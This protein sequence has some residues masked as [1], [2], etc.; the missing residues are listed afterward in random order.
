MSGPHQGAARRGLGLQVQ[1][2]PLEPEE[3]VLIEELLPSPERD[4]HA[5]RLSTQQSGSATYYV[6]WLGARP[7]GHA[8]VRWGGS[9]NP[10]LNS[11]QAGPI[12]HPYIE[13][14]AVHPA[15]QSRGIGTKIIS[16][17]EH[18]SIRR[19]HSEIGLA[20]SV[21]NVRARELYSRLGFQDLGLGEF[22][23]IWSY[24]DDT[25][26]RHVE[27]ETCVYLMKSLATP[28]DGAPDSPDL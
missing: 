28:S 17:V 4:I 24:R 27:I 5:R 23:N 20:V 19:G 21:E 22:P 13:G 8:L 14:L 18:E 1:V 11:T 12:V 16:A 3:L 6:A 2:L 26:Q 10:L 7:V 25:G 9:G 15:Y